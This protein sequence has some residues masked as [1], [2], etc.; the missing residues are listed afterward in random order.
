MSYCVNCGVEL[1]PSEPQCPLCGT[2]VI[3]PQSPWQEPPSRPYP[4]YLEIVVQRVD[5]RYFSLLAGVLLLIPV[6]L[7]LLLDLILGGGGITWSGYV[8]G[9]VAVLMVIVLVPIAWGRRRIWTYIL[10]DVAAVL[11]Y[12]YYVDLATGGLQWFLPLAAP[13][14]LS[15]G[16]VL[17]LQLHY[18][19][20]RRKKGILVVLAL[21]LFGSGVLTMLIE[22]FVRVY[23]GLSPIPRWSWSALVPC[24]LTGVAFLVLNRRNRWKESVKKRLFF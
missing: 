6:V 20:Q 19:S 8:A 2:P 18:I 4:A 5:K 13:I 9:A 22:V 1:A 11:L 23:G 15:A 10:L 14:V 7:C 16:A 24:T 17:G 12:L 3:N 21:L